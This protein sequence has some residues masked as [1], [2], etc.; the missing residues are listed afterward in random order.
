MVDWGDGI[1][2]AP[3]L[4]L[5]AEV[6]NGW[7]QCRR[8]V[9]CGIISSCRSAATS[10]IVKPFCSH[11]VKGFWASSGVLACVWRVIVYTAVRWWDEGGSLRDVT[12][13][14]MFGRL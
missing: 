3:R 2:A 5:F 12:F 9:R 14:I 8:I 6:G 1:S 10:E 7:P 4:Q 11:Y 13:G